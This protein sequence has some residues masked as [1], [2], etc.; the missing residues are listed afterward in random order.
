MLILWGSA[1]GFFDAAAQ[2]RLKAALPKARFTTFAG[3][4]HNIMWEQPKAVADAIADFLL[5]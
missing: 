5:P 4:G 3:A 2:D 1:D